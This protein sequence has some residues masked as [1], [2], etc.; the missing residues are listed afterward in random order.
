MMA[1]HSVTG[2]ANDED[3]IIGA[4]RHYYHIIAEGQPGYGGIR[5]TFIIEPL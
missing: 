3:N 4:A 2:L 5:D 1:P